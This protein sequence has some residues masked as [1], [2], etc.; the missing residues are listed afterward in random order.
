MKKEIY[1]AGGC[2]WGLQAYF[3]KINGIL[4][5]E[6][7]YANGNTNI[8]SYKEVD[9]TN[10]SET[11]RVIYDADV[12]DLDTILLYYYQVIDASSLNKQGNDIGTQYRTGIYYIDEKD[13]EIIEKSL[14]EL[15]KSYKEE[16]KIEV[17]KL[18]NYVKAEEY[19]QDYLDKNPNGYC[20]INLSKPPKIKIIDKEK[21]VKNTDNLTEL[22]YK[23]TQEAYTEKPFE[24]EYYDNFD[25]GIYVDIV[26]GEPLFLSDD[27][28][29]S[30]CGWPSFTKPI[31]KDVVDYRQDYSHNM[32]R[33]E[34]V[35]SVANSHLGHVFSDGP[36][37]TGGLRYCINSA[38]IR[39]IPYNEMEKEG[40]GK[41][42]HLLKK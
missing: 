30:T 18:K 39:F 10:H 15:Q 6:V 26:S 5:T 20:H 42:K 40:Y 29:D 2:F 32:N 31:I 36:K 38:S 33:I 4:E 25:K 12:I 35:S 34:V 3:K 37:E 14:F 13:I 23:V 9:S 19:H 1:I 27:K 8:T 22:Q 41:F 17:D 11:V 21:Y 7:G 24:N 16:I 28:Y